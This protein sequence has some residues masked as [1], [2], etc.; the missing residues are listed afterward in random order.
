MNFELM[1]PPIFVGGF[2]DT[3]EHFINE[4]QRYGFENGIN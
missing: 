1:K 3:F 2:Y 4:L